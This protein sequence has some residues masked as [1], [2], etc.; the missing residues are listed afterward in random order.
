VEDVV[1]DSADLFG[2]AYADRRVFLTGHTG[3]KGSWL[4]L[5]LTMLGARVRGY[6]L[7]PDTEP[8]LWNLLRLGA[9]DGVEDI[10]GDIRDLE[11]LRSAMA[12]F[13]PEIVF[14]LAAQALVLSS[15]DDPVGTYATNVMGTVNV[16]EAIRSV[17]CVRAV[18]VVT[19][20]KCYENREQPGYAYVESDSMGGFDPYSSSKGA[21]ELVTSAYRRSFFSTPGAA[22]IASVRAGNVIG[23]GDWAQDR[24]IPDAVRAVSK[25]EP[26][27]VRNPGAVRPWQHVLDP[28]SGY[29]MLG[30]RLVAEGGYGL[31]E[32]FNFGPSMESA[33]PVSQVMNLFTESWPGASWVSPPRTGAPHEAAF[34]TLDW[35]KARRGLGWS[36]RW[37]LAEAVSQTAEWYATVSGDTLAARAFSEAQIERF[38]S[39]E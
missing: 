39:D 15:Y 27:I 36:P 12:E 5:W 30:S 35:E 9:A 37:G 34:L 4:T 23:G 11:R 24:L 28:L 17:P 32:A 18:V 22:R 7:E 19:S 38:T 10:R 1:A 6:A 3:F 2:G 16:L 20:D 21:A 29:L 14:H 8:A 26:V 13:E 31:A 33:V 25:G